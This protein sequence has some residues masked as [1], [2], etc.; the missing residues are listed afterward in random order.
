MSEKESKSVIAGYL[1]ELQGCLQELQ[2]LTGSEGNYAYRGQENA[3][4]EVE[5]G[6]FRRL[7]PRLNFENIHPVDAQEIFISFH[8]E[9]LLEPARMDG[10]GVEEGQDLSDLELLAQLQHYGAATCL[11]DFTRN[12]LVAMW[13]ACQPPE[14]KDGKGKDGKEEDGKIF[15]LDT[16]DE[17][18]LPLEMKDL[19]KDLK[20][21]LAFQTRDETTT[22]EEHS[23]QEEQPEPL[24]RHWSPRSL[25]QRIMKQDSLF[26]FGQPKMENMPLKEIKIL[27]EDKSEIWEELERLGITERTLFKDLPG[28]ADTHRKNSSLPREYGTP[29]Y[30][31][32]KGKKAF[33]RGDHTDAIK[34]YTRV[35]K[36]KDDL[37]A[38]AYNKRG[39]VKAAL[40]NYSGAIEDYDEAIKL[41]PDFAEAH[42]N[43]ADAKSRQKIDEED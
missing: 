38:E 25:N 3:K 23:L 24:W 18:F 28:F 15:I 4:W 11:I 20:D 40:G 32:Q 27:G 41:K 16:S 43:R 13:F 21:F 2:E 42:K 17:N 26:I 33:K 7:D 14:E 37:V 31:F 36:F 1:Q 6:A 19:K 35:I 29:K 22:P 30:Y 34:Y 5:S 8:E 10:Y 9:E 39:V 12:F